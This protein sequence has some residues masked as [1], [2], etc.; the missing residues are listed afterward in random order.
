MTAR[1]STRSMPSLVP[2][3]AV[4]ETKAERLYSMFKEYNALCFDNEIKGFTVIWGA[5]MYSVSGLTQFDERY[6]KISACIHES[7]P[8]RETRRTLLHEMI[9][10]WLFCV[11]KPLSVCLGHGQAF[12]RK[13]KLVNQKV[14]FDIGVDHLMALETPSLNDRYEWQCQHCGHVA[15]IR[16]FRKLPDP[17]YGRHPPC[18]AQ[19]WRLTRLRQDR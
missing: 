4:S 14:G 7:L 3:P 10:A 18:P 19:R 12:R 1:R 5:R 15:R 11:G 9:H 13:M 2:L 8:E 17:F 6:I 16:V